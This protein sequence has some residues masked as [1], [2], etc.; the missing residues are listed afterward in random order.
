MNSILFHVVLLAYLL[1][2]LG[3]LVLPRRAAD[4]AIPRGQCLGLRGIGLS[5]YPPR[6]TA[7]DPNRVEQCVGLIGAT[8]L[9]H[10]YRVRC[11]MV[12]T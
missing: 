2:T 8:G 1:A 3:F 10:Q 12:V 5:D 6:P 9:G 7:R 4:L 11:R